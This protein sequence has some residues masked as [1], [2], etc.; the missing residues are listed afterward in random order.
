MLMSPRNVEEIPDVVYGYANG[1]PLRLNIAR[2]KSPPDEP[3]PA[4]VYIHGGAWIMGDYKGPWNYPFAARGY[5][6]ANVEYRLSGESVF[7]AQIH[8]CKAAI[9]WLRAHREEYNIDHQRIGV[10]GHSAGGHLAALLGTSHDVE[11]LEGEEG[12]EGLPS[13]VQA[14]IDLFGPTDLSQ[15]IG[16]QKYSSFLEAAEKLVDGRLDEREALVKMANPIAYV[17][18]DDPPFLIIHGENDDVVPFSQSQLLHDALRK[19]GVGSTLVKVKNAGHG[20]NPN[21]DGA[22]VEPNIHEINELISDFFDTHL[23]KERPLAN[24]FQT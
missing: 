11:E 23:R 14:V 21:P 3:M 13:L 1:R 16:T 12:S 19:A 9:R 6:T 5:F 22:M 4:I 17:T 18:P 10:W 8:D 2:P 15:I 20:F 24:P 7:P